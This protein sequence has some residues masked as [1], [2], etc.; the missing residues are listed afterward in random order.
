MDKFR[1]GQ[2]VRIVKSF[3]D[4]PTNIIVTIIEPRKIRKSKQLGLVFA[5]KSDNNRI[6]LEEQYQEIYDGD[7]KSSWSTCEWQPKY[8]K[9][10]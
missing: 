2:K 1:V 5:Y 7:E 10:S 6:G 4:H 9:T 8:K 3:A